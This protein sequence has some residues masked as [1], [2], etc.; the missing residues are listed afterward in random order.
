MRFAS[1]ERNIESAITS[2]AREIENGIGGQRRAI[3]AQ[4]EVDAPELCLE[5]GAAGYIVELACHRSGE[6]R[7]SA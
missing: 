6:P 4:R 1:V 5:R 7:M 2:I 3:T